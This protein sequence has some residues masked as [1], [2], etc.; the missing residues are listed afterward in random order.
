MIFVGSKCITKFW[1]AMVFGE[2]G[3]FIEVRESEKCSKLRHMRP[4]LRFCEGLVVVVRE[5]CEGFGGEKSIICY[6]DK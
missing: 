4:I 2:S 6:R 1:V 3:G 5:G